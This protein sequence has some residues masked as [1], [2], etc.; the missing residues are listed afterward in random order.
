ME[1]GCLNGLRETCF[2]IAEG[3]I[4]D[5]KARE[6]LNR[7]WEKHRREFARNSARGCVLKIALERFETAWADGAGRETLMDRVSAA[8]T[9]LQTTRA[10][11]WRQVE[12]RHGKIGQY[13]RRVRPDQAAVPRRP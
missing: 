11:R 12:R 4:T 6:G 13:V 7:L 5:L 3:K 9:V 1:N 8:D 10:E 2:E